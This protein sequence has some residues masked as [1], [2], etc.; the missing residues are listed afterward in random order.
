MTTEKNRLIRKF[1]ALLSKHGISNEEKLAMLASYGAT[2]STEMNTYELLEL[3]DKLSRS[4]SPTE[5]SRQKWMRRLMA[6]VA[7]YLRET[8]KKPMAEMVK[9]VI[10]RA[11]GYQSLDQIPED[12]LRSLYNAFNHRV[13]DLRRVD[14]ITVGLLTGK[15]GEA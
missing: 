2:S 8:G 7:A 1:H 10:R 11:S 6:V 14:E 5:Q 15:G 13:K 9:G 4:L 3:C 12:R